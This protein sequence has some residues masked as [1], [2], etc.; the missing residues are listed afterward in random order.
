MTSFIQ[1]MTNSMQP[2]LIKF[3]LLYVHAF[4]GQRN[5]RF[6]NKCRTR[7]TNVCSKE[8]HLKEN[9]NAAE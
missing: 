4:G 8:F 1:I 9:E 2:R 3:L 5:Y 7:D 6:M